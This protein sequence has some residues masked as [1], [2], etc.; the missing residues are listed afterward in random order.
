MWLNWQSAE[1]D[2]GRRMW[3][4]A[5]LTCFK[6]V[7]ILAASHVKGF[8][9]LIWLYN[10]WHT[11][12]THQVHPVQSRV[13]G[14][15]FDKPVL[16]SYAYEEV[17]TFQAEVPTEFL[18]DRPNSADNLSPGEMFCPFFCI[19]KTLLTSFICGVCSQLFWHKLVDFSQ[20]RI[21]G[22]AQFFSC[23]FTFVGLSLKTGFAEG[24]SPPMF[25][26]T[27]VTWN[28]LSFSSWKRAL[29]FIIC[30]LRLFS[31]ATT[32]YLP[33]HR[34]IEFRFFS[35]CCC[36][37]CSSC[38]VRTDSRRK[39]TECTLAKKKRKNCDPVIYDQYRASMK[40]QVGS[41][42]VIVTV[43]TACGNNGIDI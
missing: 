23:L 14:L 15:H 5:V 41:E 18:G 31:K 8:R 1:R 4:R 25:Q 32:Y 40:C 30:T 29:Y 38:K 13:N 9:F 34:I 26:G 16:D 6:H 3:P 24:N 42:V 10:T 22:Y 39:Q 43:K 27:N 35:F 19:Y 21:Q 11:W 33:V 37:Y 12:H 2:H 28:V 7:V 36:I 17:N 20:R